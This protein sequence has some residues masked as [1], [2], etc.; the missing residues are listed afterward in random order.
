MLVFYSRVLFL[1]IAFAII[2]FSLPLKFGRFLAFKNLVVSSLR[3]MVT[4]KVAQGL[5]VGLFI[6]LAYSNVLGN[7]PG[8]YT[9]TQF[10]SVVIALRLRF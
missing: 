5:L 1:T 2:F 3:T 4:S 10:Y 6:F 7:I 8:N 9:P